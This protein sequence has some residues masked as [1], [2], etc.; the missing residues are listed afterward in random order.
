MGCVFFYVSRW[1]QWGVQLNGSTMKYE[2]KWRMLRPS[3]FLVKWLVFGCFFPYPSTWSNR[4]QCLQVNSTQ[5]LEIL[6]VSMKK[7]NRP[8]ACFTLENPTIS[9]RNISQTLI[10]KE[11]LHKNDK[12][13]IWRHFARSV[14]SYSIRD[15]LFVSFQ[16]TNV[17]Q[18][19]KYS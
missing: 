2:W 9:L 19:H 16:Q 12:G 17:F 15:D 11:Y 4:Q 5:S 14:K 13:A 3:R 10:S 1:F 7:L 8:S 6:S 18:C